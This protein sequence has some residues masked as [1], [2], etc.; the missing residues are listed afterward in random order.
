MLL[1][2]DRIRHR[3]KWD[4][5]HLVDRILRVK[6][7]MGHRGNFGGPKMTRAGD[8]VPHASEDFD[9]LADNRI[10]DKPSGQFISHR[11]RTTPVASLTV[12]VSRGVARRRNRATDDRRDHGCGPRDNKAFMTGHPGHKYQN[13]QQA[14]YSALKRLPVAAQ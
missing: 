14:P 2:F 7:V 11:Q 1:R 13:V 8:A 3:L 10:P 6:S 12:C 5:E 9:C 4:F